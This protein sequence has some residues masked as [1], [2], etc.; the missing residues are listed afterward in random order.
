MNIA[1]SKGSRFRKA[2]R[3]MYGD[4]VGKIIIFTIV[5]WMIG[6]IVEGVQFLAGLW[7]SVFGLVGPAFGGALILAFI[8]EAAK[9]KEAE[10]KE[11]DAEEK[12]PA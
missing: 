8:I 6:L 1:E 4:L 9:E 2:I 5:F 7:P 11:K 12:E 3:R 10:R